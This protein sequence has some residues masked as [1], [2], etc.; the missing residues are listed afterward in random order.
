MEGNSKKIE[1]CLNGNSVTFFA[2][3]LVFGGVCSEILCVK[4]AFLIWVVLKLFYEI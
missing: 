3:W 1:N 4:R 2:Y